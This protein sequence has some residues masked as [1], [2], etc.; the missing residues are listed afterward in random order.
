MMR[1]GA[2]IL[3]GGAKN[4]DG[5]LALMGT[6]KG[7]FVTSPLFWPACA[8]HAISESRAVLV[9][10]INNERGKRATAKTSRTKS[11]LKKH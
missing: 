2:A 7:V 5:L 11:I 8:M 4:K 6:T 1:A 3:D 10:P 9:V